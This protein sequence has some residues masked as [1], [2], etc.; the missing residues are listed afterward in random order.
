M[1]GVSQT[2][3]LTPHLPPV[4]QRSVSELEYAAVLHVCVHVHV[5]HRPCG[6]TQFV[7]DK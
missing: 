5:H 4:S 6:V 1:E 3:V 7:S 2:G